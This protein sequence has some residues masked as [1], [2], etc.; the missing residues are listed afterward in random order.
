MQKKFGQKVFPQELRA[1]R[2]CN[3][4]EDFASILYRIIIIHTLINHE[5]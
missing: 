5:N 4:I 1:D 3:E 2:T